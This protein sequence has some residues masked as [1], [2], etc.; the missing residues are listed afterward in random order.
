MVILAFTGTVFGAV[1]YLDNTYA[2]KSKLERM[3]TLICYM[4]KKLD[5]FQTQTLCKHIIK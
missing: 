3:D 4:A 5:V 2:R 1:S